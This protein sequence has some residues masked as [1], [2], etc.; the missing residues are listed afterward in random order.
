[1]KR[2][3]TTRSARAV[4]LVFC[5]YAL[6]GAAAAQ[7]GP[8]VSARPERRTIRPMPEGAA[9]GIR[10]SL[11][12][13]IGLA[14]ANNQDLN[15]SV[16]S[17]EASRFTLFENT[18]I[19][20]PLVEAS[21]TRAHDEEP[22]SSQLI[23]AQ[24]FESDTFD[25]SARVTQLA[26]TGGTASLGFTTRRSSTNST[27]SF[28][29]PSYASGLTLSVRQP[30]LRS[31]GELPTKWLIYT[32]RNSRD[33]AYQDFVRSVQRTV[34]AVEAA[35]WDLVFA[36]QNLE[37]KKEALRVAQ[38][39]NRITRIR[40]DVGSLAPIDIVQTEVG[41]A[42][43][44]QEIIIAEGLIGDA[45]DRLKRLLNFESSKW[46]VP[47]V[48]TDTVQTE[49]QD[50]DAEKGALTAMAKRPDLLAA[51]YLTDS[52]RIRYDYLRNQTLP[53]LDLV[54]SY[55][56]RGLGGTT[57][58]RDEETGEVLQRIPGDFGDSLDQIRDTDFNNWSLGL[59]FS[60]P[61]FNRAARGARGQAKWTW[62]ASKAN[63]TALEQNV[64]LEVRAAARAIDTAKRSVV[65]AG[66]SRE[67]ADR[68]LDAERKKFENG[69][70]TSFQ[71]TQIQNE[72]SAARSNELQAQLVYRKA[73]SAFHFA[74]A[75]I[76]DWKGIRI[77]D[78]PEAQPPSAEA[79]AVGP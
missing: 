69:M 51:T 42:T 6:S 31:L 65:A 20:D 4:P 32:S 53:Q 47:V 43:A 21:L 77:E 13:A 68:N 27:F 25:A 35:Y 64:L 40:I 34:D 7:E 56:F 71:V 45:Q 44:E 76:L 17:A 75:D 78:V 23:G 72:L 26:P 66:K 37:V 79:R 36:L 15:V 1:M 3:L 58:I 46:N 11:A 5:L 10:L 61:I 18:G 60:Y 12:D 74:I 57:T 50:V 29:N 54:G 16:S 38:D 19:F 41:T 30:L 8:V 49:L 14:L 55:G 70:T 22:A 28:V 2:F 9:E 59:Q 73:L 52:D 33:A 48:P 63:L 39:L 62:E 67:L 24:V